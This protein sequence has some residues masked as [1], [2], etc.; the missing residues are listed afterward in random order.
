MPIDFHE[1]SR[2][3][4]KLVF[5]DSDNTI[6]V[7]E[8]ER[9]RWLSLNSDL[10]QALIRL[11]DPTEIML[12]YTYSMLLAL[13]YKPSPKRLLNLGA[14]CGSFERFLLKHYPDLMI[15][16]VESNSEMIKIAKKYFHLAAEH[17]VINESADILIKTTE[18]QYDIIFCDLHDGKKHPGYLS[19]PDFYNDIYKRLNDK[20]VLV[21]N[22]ILENDQALLDILLPLR[23]LFKWQN[24]LDFDDYGNILLFAFN[25]RPEKLSS[26]DDVFSLLRSKTGLE[27]SAVLERLKMLPTAQ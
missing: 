20:G 4:S 12:P 9:Y 11:S 18:L 5:E 6:K 17:P 23:S 21:M 24:L 14:G 8:D 22:L 2:S 10:V 16:S 25:S 15:T 3:Q 1:L 27:L 7:F 19:D 26:D 13:A